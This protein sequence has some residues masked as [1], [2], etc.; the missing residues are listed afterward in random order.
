M[1][2]LVGLLAQLDPLDL[3]PALGIEQAQLHALGLL[4][5]EREVHALA[6]PGRAERIRP[7]GP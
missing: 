6:V 7:T 1:P 5:E 3:A 4:R 2:D